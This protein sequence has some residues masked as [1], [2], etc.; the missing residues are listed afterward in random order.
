M[1]LLIILSKKNWEKLKLSISGIKIA[2]NGLSFSG[3]HTTYN[4]NLEIRAF[5]TSKKKAFKKIL[6]KINPVLISICNK[7]KEI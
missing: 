1:D 4:I 3:L 5:A 2:M 7:N 6:R